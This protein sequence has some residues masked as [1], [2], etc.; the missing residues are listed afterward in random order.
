MPTIY[1]HAKALLA[2]EYAFAVRKTELNEKFLINQTQSG[3]QRLTA[4]RRHFSL[5]KTLN[6]NFESNLLSNVFRLNNLN[7]LFMSCIFLM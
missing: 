5:E 3:F 2:H 4:F 6:Q 7:T 1:F